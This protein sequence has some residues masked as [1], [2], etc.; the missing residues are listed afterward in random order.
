MSRASAWIAALLLVA[1]SGCAGAGERRV[2]LGAGVG[3]I[4]EK[5]AK[6]PAFE[7]AVP[8]GYR[9]ARL[10]VERD[11]VELAYDDEAGPAVTVILRIAAAGPEGAQD[12]NGSRFD[13]HLEDLRGGL[14]EGSRLAMLGAAMAVDRAIPERE[15]QSCGGGRPGP[16]ETRAPGV[17]GLSMGLLQ[18]A[19]ILAALA[20]VLTGRR[21]SSR[22]R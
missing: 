12:G 7:A 16:P 20:V 11:H 9:L 5:L 22:A 15:L 18:V 1:A 21:R 10:D 13:H 14:V 6:D 3:E 19:I 17:F 2:C 8:S 4:L